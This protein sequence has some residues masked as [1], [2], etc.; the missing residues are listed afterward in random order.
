MMAS[1]HRSQ[2]PDPIQHTVRLFEESGEAAWLVGGATRDLLLGRE[3]KDWDFVIGGDGLSWARRIANELGGAFVAL[4][5][6]REVGRAVVRHEGKTLW[7]D[8]ARFRDEANQGGGSSLEGDL[9]LR[10]FTAN[11]IALDPLTDKITDPTGGR[12]DLEARQLRAAGP[13]S[14]QDDPLRV[15]RAVRLQATRGLVIEEETLELMRAAAPLLVQ[16]A[17]ERVREEWLKLLAPFGA[18][19]RVSLLDELGVV[20]VL[21]PE[22]ARCKG[23]TQSLPHSHD[24]YGHSLLVLEAMEQLWPWLDEDTFWQGKLAA[25]AAAMAEH[26][27]QELAHEMPRWLLLKHVALLHDVGKPATRTVGDDGRIHFYKHDAVGARI[28]EEQMRHWKFP[29]RAVEYGV[30]VVFQHLRPLQLSNNL[31]PSDRAVYRYFR[32][33]GDDGPDVALHSVA[34]QRGKTFASDRSEVLAVVVR[35]L[36]AYFE[37][38]ER[39][40]RPTPLLDGHEIM[41]ISE[42][43]GPAIGEA[44]E[45]LRE[46]QAQGRVR[47]QAQAEALIRGFKPGSTK[48][49]RKGG[50]RR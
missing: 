41:K 33:M 3:V 30:R 17:V 7:I 35:L 40:V 22:L 34:D 12:A 15:L 11:A 23:V 10:D 50:K 43:R 14:F 37:Q 39:Y 4:D 31:P 5:E 42:L 32:D 20:D 38:P 46:Q 6:E 44:L 2:F 16:V 18:M 26:L 21:L 8:V 28:I 47:T 49:K 1:I 29:T 13:R 25:H 19:E 27:R 24:V 9:R 36:E 45:L 48:P